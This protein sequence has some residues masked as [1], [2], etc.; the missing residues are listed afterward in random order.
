MT[1]SLIHDWNLIDSTPPPT[2]PQ[3]D[4]ETLRDGLQSPSVK[5]PSLEAMV[6]ILHLMSKLGIESANI[7]LP[8]AGPHVEASAL[9]L[10]QEIVSED[11][12]I[13]PNCAARTLQVD[14][15]PIVRI[16]QATGLRMEASTFIGSSP[17]RQY[18]EGWTIEQMIQ[19]TQTAVSFA[20]E[21]GLEVMMVTEDTTRAHPDT[22]K[23]LYGT[24]IACGAKRICVCDTV[25]HATPDGV[26]SL[27]GFVRAFADE[28][29]DDIQVDWHGHRDR[30]L[31][32]VNTLVAVESGA[33]RIHGT[34][35]G[36]GERVGNTPMDQILVNLKLLGWIKRDLSFLSDYV[37][38]VSKATGVPI[39]KGYPVIGEDA[40][41]TGTGVHAAAVIKAMD[42]GDHWLA[43]RV[44][45][46][47]PAGDF[48]LRQK[49]E[50]G[51]MSGKSNVVFWLE[52]HGYE[53]S[54]ERVN[55]LFEA[56][57]VSREICDE[58]LLHNLAQ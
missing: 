13:F 52:E 18:A 48:G 40:F 44:Y 57:K 5:T 28:E 50:V 29:G 34:A 2:P 33:N 47:V 15:E 42:K 38:K 8:G 3:L 41:R 30:G 14:I 43:D 58:D 53:A 21:N 24:A 4:D 37:H 10:A 36:I 27:V 35:L 11:L 12:G 46:G 39:P 9:R 1:D 55:R 32:L 54:E 6:E 26:R 25:G 23:A 16:Q 7:G 51:P 19:S 45:S 20:V 56:A 31:D 49:I 22:L 17:I